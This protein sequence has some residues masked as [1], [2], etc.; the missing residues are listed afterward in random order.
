M[1]HEV[2]ITRRQSIFIFLQIQA[3]AGLRRPVLAGAGWYWMLRPRPTEAHLCLDF[4]KNCKCFAFWLSGPH[5]TS[6][7]DHQFLIH[8]DLNYTNVQSTYYIEYTVSPNT[9]MGSSFLTKTYH[10]D[11]ACLL[12]SL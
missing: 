4:Q 3:E 10:N 1:S 12:F 7:F 11:C 9:I 5:G 6:N 8:S 2:L